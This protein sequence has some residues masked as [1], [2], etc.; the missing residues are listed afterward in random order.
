MGRGGADE[1]GRGAVGRDGAGDEDG[2]VGWG[3]AWR[4]GG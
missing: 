4:G 2:G 3:G 1:E